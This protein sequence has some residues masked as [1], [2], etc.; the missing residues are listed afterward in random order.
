MWES[1]SGQSGTSRF[2]S[3]WSQ[4]LADGS[5]PSLA[6]LLIS[7]PHMDHYGLIDQV[8]ARVPLFIGKEADR[9]PQS[10]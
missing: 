7:H 1:H 8:D 6:G 2:H 9:P 5:D 4:G 3:R 10:G